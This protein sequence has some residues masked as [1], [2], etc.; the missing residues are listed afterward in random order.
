MRL[1]FVADAILFTADGADID[2][3]IGGLLLGAP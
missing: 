2:V 3:V 1:F